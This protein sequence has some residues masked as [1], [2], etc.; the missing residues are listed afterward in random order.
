MRALVVFHEVPEA[1]GGGLCG[2]S[3]EAIARGAGKGHIS[4][5]GDY[6]PVD[7]RR[8]IFIFKE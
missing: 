3:A 5:R 7:D 2:K 8:R 4:R 6:R 1:V